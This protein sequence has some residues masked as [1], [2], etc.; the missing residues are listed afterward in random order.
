MGFWHGRRIFDN[1]FSLWEALEWAMQ[2]NQKLAIV[3]L[4]FDKAYDKVD[5]DFL[6][7]TLLRFEFTNVW[8]RWIPSLYI[9]AHSQVLIGGVKS[10]RFHIS[11]SIW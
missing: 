10:E 4:D 9:S 3:L 5:W 2:S 8:I 6:E 11:R 7:G 1:I